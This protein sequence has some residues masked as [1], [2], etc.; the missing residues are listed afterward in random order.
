MK[1]K[2]VSVVF[3]LSLSLPLLAQGTSAPTLWDKYKEKA[4]PYLMQT[5]G[6]EWT[7]KLLGATKLIASMPTLP[8]ISDD[9]KTMVSVD[10][11]K[12]G[13]PIEDKAVREKYDYLFLNE[14]FLAVRGEKVNQDVISSWMNSLSQGG[15]REGVYQ[16]I[17]LDNIYGGMENRE[18]PVN[19]GV[20]KFTVKFMPRFLG[21]KTTSQGLEGVNFYRLKREVTTRS[22]HML[23]ALA[24][25][26]P[27]DLYQ[28]YAAFSSELADE[29]PSVMNNSARTNR[30][31]AFHYKWA[32]SA[33]YQHLKS[34][35]MIKIQLV[36]NSL[37]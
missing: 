4:R 25:Q 24:N 37:Y 3:C 22:L 33:P 23:D 29:F 8:K 7:V 35:V 12:I 16:A 2:L 32:Q 13:K 26:K 10:E 21:V 5:I 11:T 1:R 15:S 34:E 28:W 9:T 30:D 14:L 6:E 18:Y 36:F 27:E 31:F 19:D 17:V 20:I